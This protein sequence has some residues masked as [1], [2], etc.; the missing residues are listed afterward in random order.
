MYDLNN[1]FTSAYSFNP[2]TRPKKRDI[3]RLR[4]LWFCL[5]PNNKINPIFLKLYFFRQGIHWLCCN[6]SGLNNGM[7]MVDFPPSL[8]NTMI[9][10]ENNYI[11]FLLLLRPIYYITTVLLRILFRSRMQKF[12]WLL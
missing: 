6:L 11:A 3:L 10:V 8:G 9:F 4:T 1:F 7:K 5:P 12:E 2:S